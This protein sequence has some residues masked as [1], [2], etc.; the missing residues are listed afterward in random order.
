[1]SIKARLLGLIFIALQ[2][3]VAFAEKLSVECPPTIET[4]ESAKDV[5]DSWRLEQ[6]LGKRGKFLDSISIYSGPPKEMATLVPDKTTQK[7]KKRKSVWSFSNQSNDQYWVACTY[8]NSSLLLTKPLP[9]GTK[10][11]ELSESLLATGV[12]LAV[13]SLI[14]E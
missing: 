12:K 8:T 13:E 7:S 6:D 4:N 10:K 14:C 2:S 11:C 5:G 1:M 9:K 3:V